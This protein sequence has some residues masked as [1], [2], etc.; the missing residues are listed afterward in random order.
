MCVCF[1]VLAE[2]EHKI[3]SPSG[4]LSSPNWPDKYPSRKECTWDITAVPGHRVKIVS[5]RS[6][7]ATA[8][9]CMNF[10]C[11]AFKLLFLISTWFLFSCSFYETQ[12]LTQETWHVWISG[13]TASMCSCVHKRAWAT[14]ICVL[15]SVCVFC[16]HS[17]L[18]CCTSMY[19]R[20]DVLSALWITDSL[21]SWCSILL[22]LNQLSFIYIYFL[23]RQCCGLHIIIRRCQKWMDSVKKK[24]SQW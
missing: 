14:T 21:T 16:T 12:M 6:T 13:L 9:V 23:W 24:T 10:A 11:K 15:A 20:Q 1:C 3:H 8:F 18:I 17:F 7:E 5:E 2:C 19:W 22:L 4:T